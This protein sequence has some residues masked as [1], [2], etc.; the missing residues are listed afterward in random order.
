MEW[1]LLR[2]ILG[3]VGRGAAGQKGRDA[4]EGPRGDGTTALGPYAPEETEG[5]GGG[6]RYPPPRRRIR[7]PAEKEVQGQGLEGPGGCRGGWTGGGVGRA[8]RRSV[9]GEGPTPKGRG[10]GKHRPWVPC[11]GD[12]G[13]VQVPRLPRGLLPGTPLSP[14]RRGP[15]GARGAS[16]PA[17]LPLALGAPGDVVF[18]LL[19]PLLDPPVRPPL[20][21]QNSPPL[22]SSVKEAP[23]ASRLEG[24]GECR[25]TA[26]GRGAGVLWTWSGA[27]RVPRA[28]PPA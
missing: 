14:S 9:V 24:G 26:A 15:E 16:S 27:T 6:S 21:L 5:P 25:A 20:P 28:A 1:A 18:P 12:G 10:M 7:R 17:F 2:D 4:G 11:G 22:P 23:T 8:R 19:L 3:V 13:E